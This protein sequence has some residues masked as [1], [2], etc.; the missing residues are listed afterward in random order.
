LAAGE[1]SPD[2]NHAAGHYAAAGALLDRH[3]I[4][5]YVIDYRPD[6]AP[7]QVIAV[8]H[9]KRDLKRFW[10]GGP[11][12]GRGACTANGGRSR[13][14]EGGAGK[15]ASRRFLEF[16]TVNIRNKNTRAAYGRALSV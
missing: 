4:P 16:F 11:D 10:K 5:H 7:L 14:V 15:R 9:S 13:S 2:G 3:E 1:T 6:V 12:E 8:L